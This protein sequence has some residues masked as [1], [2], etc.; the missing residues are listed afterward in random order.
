M[1]PILLACLAG[2]PVP[3]RAAAQTVDDV[4]GTLVYWR[5]SPPSVSGFALPPGRIFTTS[6][7]IVVLP[8]GDYLL[9]FNLFGSDL[10]PP[11]ET[12]GT[13][14]VYRSSDRGLTW[15][16]L[17][18]APMM[19]MKRGSL[20]VFGSDVYLWG[21]TAAPGNVVIRKSSDGGVTWTV[22]TSATTGLLA[23]NDVFG[24]TPSN[25]V[26][27]EGRIWTPVSGKRLMSV[28]TARNFLEATRW[29]GPSTAA[30]TDTGPLGSG[31]TLSEAQIVASPQT[32]V[33]VLPKVDGLPWTVL[34][35]AAGNGSVADPASTDW[36]RL[37]GGDKK[38]AASY[39]PVSGRFYVLSNPVLP[40]HAATPGLT[41][42][43][44]RNTATLS[45]S[46]DLVH[47]DVQQIFLYSPHVA[48][49]A[50]QYFNFDFDGDDL[51]VASRT[52][53]DLTD[54]PGSG[55]LLPP[56]GHDSNAITFH[57]IPD[58]RTAS[59]TQV[60]SIAGN[61]VLR[62]ERT[63]H[64]DAPLGSF[65]LGTSFGGAALGTVSGLAQSAGGEIL[66]REAAGRVLRFDALGNF[67]GP[68]SGAGVTFSTTLDPVAQPAPGERG[69]TA[70]GGG[71][72]DALE[73][74]HYW[75]RPDTDVEVANLG[76]A[77]DADAS[78]AVGGDVRLRGLR[79]LGPRGYTIAGT[80][81]IE[82]ATADG[83]DAFLLAQVGNHVLDVALRIA[84]DARIGASD[85]A[86]VSLD[87]GLDVSGR[88]V[89]VEGPGTVRV[90]TSLSLGGG[91]LVLEQGAPLRLAPGAVV[92]LG[93]TLEW[94]AL[95]GAVFQEGDGF[96]VL[97][98]V[99]EAQSVAGFTGFVLPDAGPGLG[100]DVTALL[101]D[102]TISVAALGCGNGAVTLDETCDDGNRS[103][104][105]CCASDCQAAAAAGTSCA[106]DDS[107]CTR[108]ACDG[109]GV[110]AHA[111]PA[112]AS[113]RVGAP[114]RGLLQ[115]QKGSEPARDR[116]WWTW[117]TTESVAKAEFGDPVSGPSSFTLCVF[118][119][120]G[121]LLFDA[122]ARAAVNCGT[123]PCWRETTSGFA[124][125]DSSPGPDGASSVRLTG[126][127][128]PSRA[129]LSFAGR[130]A[131]LGLQGLPVTALPLRAR[132]LRSDSPQCW[133]SSHSSPVRN[134]AAWFKAL[135][136]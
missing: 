25:P 108:D 79:L 50:F 106:A 90:G 96:E 107:P 62:S 59:P 65:V 47:W 3:F 136:D 31:L 58:F 69:W 67:L 101:V 123:M 103:D 21:Y 102:G 68:A 71:D 75:N 117:K 97:G 18:P 109:L 98:D 48:Y 15:T 86:G 135:A 88:R 6:P 28:N 2:L 121:R 113:C 33:V 11:A 5:P 99:G 60:L 100:W 40:A 29:A 22:P 72:W 41:P 30:D 12:S 104:G 130:G 129:T 23:S 26:V 17:T 1:V 95:P 119:D 56:R 63:Q 83:S 54:E 128:T 27:H 124:Y 46:P 118:G 74:W 76:S 131:G 42:Q 8:G 111:V 80:G 134:G 43:L 32:G 132:L 14:F 51:V 77:V 89:R 115:V 105:D 61:R 4:P 38:F 34:I 24:G 112:A 53:F 7:S 85:G 37:P 70:S 120:D 20:F 13:T 84:G 116:V 133:E 10:V 9:S 110:C 49:E 94:H 87:G 66:V 57:R 126:S 125:R 44:I 16:N 93:G 92:D 45:S 64:A 36:V 82:L 114:G 52:A 39:D 122:T 78:I 73:N 81:K 127:P 19:D 55:N 35:R 91:T